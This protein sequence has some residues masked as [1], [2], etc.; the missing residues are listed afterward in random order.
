MAVSDCVYNGDRVGTIVPIGDLEDLSRN[1]SGSFG[2][3]C[4]DYSYCKL[5]GMDLSGGEY[6]GF[7]FL[8]SDLTGVKFSRVDEDVLVFGDSEDLGEPTLIPSIGEKVDLGNRVYSDLVAA[9]LVKT[10]LSYADLTLCDLG[11]AD[12]SYS[13][14]RGTNLS[15]ANL[16]GARLLVVDDCAS[17]RFSN[18]F[19]D[20]DTQVSLDVFKEM[21]EQKVDFS[22]GIT[23][24]NCDLG[25]LEKYVCEK[26]IEN[27]YCEGR[28][29]FE[30]EDSEESFEVCESSLGFFGGLKN[31]SEALKKVLTR[32]L[33]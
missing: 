25:N 26:K 10:N 11:G 32:K 30:N 19:V 7:S 16:C 31:V 33:W 13:R 18:V 2:V 12:L 14:L 27:V 24:E 8:R 28:L 17:V 15:Y 21:Y 9:N 5:F 29:I 22:E 1:R 6:N 23:V 20:R 3:D 4:S